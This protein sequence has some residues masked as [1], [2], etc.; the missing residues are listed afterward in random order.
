MVAENYASKISISELIATRRNFQ[1]FTKFKVVK[2][3]MKNN[4][5]KKQALIAIKELYQKNLEN[6]KILG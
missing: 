2:K 1:K 6:Y 5:S 3:A 4:Y